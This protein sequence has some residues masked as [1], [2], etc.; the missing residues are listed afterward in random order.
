MLASAHIDETQKRTSA[1]DPAGRHNWEASPMKADELYETVTAQLIAEIEAGAGDWKMPWHSLGVSGLA[2]SIDERPYRG[3]NALILSIASA[4][5]GWQSTSWGTYKAWQRHGQQVER[6]QR[7]TKVLLWKESK[8]ANG[9][10]EDSRRL[11]AR[12]FTVFAREQTD[13]PPLSDEL[14]TSDDGTQY[15][16]AHAEL[17]A[18]GAA[19]RPSPQPHY[20]KSADAIGMPDRDAF[21]SE[22]FYLSTF[23]HECIHWTGHPSRID[24]DMSGRFGDQAYG[25]E[26]LV[27]EIGS[28]FWCARH[29]VTD[30]A[31]RLDHADYLADWLR[32]LRKDSRAILTAASKAQAADDYIRQCTGTDRPDTIG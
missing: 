32:I 27:A 20:A 23:A 11:F 9:E 29:S 10:P 13:A 5:H 2:R 25:F 8:P 12:T 21:E 19:V 31:R 6:G 18:T 30:P 28:A 3:L 22:A 4:S 7:G 26:E 14:P 1:R 16:D 24:R 15:V 17:A